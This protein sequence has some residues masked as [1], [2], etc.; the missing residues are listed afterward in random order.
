MASSFY[1]TN[2]F[3][4]TIKGYANFIA[5]DIDDDEEDDSDFEREDPSPCNRTP[6]NRSKATPK[7]LAPN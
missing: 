4:Q 7:K 6:Q 2:E 1:N 5:Q 3:D